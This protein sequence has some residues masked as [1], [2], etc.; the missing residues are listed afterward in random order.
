MKDRLENFIRD[1]KKE[2][3]QFDPPAALWDKIEQQLE[4]KRINSSATG[5]KKEKVV[6]L[7]FLLKMAATIVVVLGVGLW[8]YQYQKKESADLSNIDP[9]LAKQQVHYTSLIE[10]KQTELKQI[11]KEEPQ[12]YSEFSSEIRKMDASYQKLKSDLP[13]SPN[14]EETVKA[15]IRNL[16]IQTELLNQQL[17]IIQQINNVKKEQKHETQQI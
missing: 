7:S 4:E 8:G 9:K 14:Q 6:R 15:M 2:F 16:Q 3:D 13:A 12:L 1:N 11:E 17:N 10:A 5:I